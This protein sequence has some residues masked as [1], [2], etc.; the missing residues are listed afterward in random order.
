MDGNMIILIDKKRS[1]FLKRE[2]F[3]KN[4]EVLLKFGCKYDR[5]VIWSGVKYIK[6]LVLGFRNVGEERIV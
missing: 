3:C 6:K 4:L 5:I 2:G 1:V